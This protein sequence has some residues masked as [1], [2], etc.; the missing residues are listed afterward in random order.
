MWFNEVTTQ[1]GRDALGWYHEKIDADR[2][3]GLGP[4][5]DWSSHSADA[6]GLMAIAYEIPEDEPPPF[7]VKRYQPT[8]GGGFP[9]QRR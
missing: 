5:H 2:G 3:I 9:Q 7:D 4:D 6:C 1:G 8:A